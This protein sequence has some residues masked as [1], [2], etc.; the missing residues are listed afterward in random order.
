MVSQYVLGAVRAAT[1]TLRSL[2]V[3]YAIFGEEWWFAGVE[4]CVLLKL[5]AGRPIDRADA[6]ELL[7]LHRARIDEESLR[8]SA[9][10]LGVTDALGD[11]LKAAEGPEPA[12]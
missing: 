9:G 3:E 4:D 1:G 12:F 10:R 6:A 11:A 2:G 8:A 5:I 7:R